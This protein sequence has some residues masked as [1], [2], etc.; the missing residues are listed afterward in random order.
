MV[1]KSVKG[2]ILKGNSKGLSFL[3]KRG[4]TVMI[5]ANVKGIVLGGLAGYLILSKG[6]NVMANCVRNICVAHQWKN[7]YKYGKDGNMVPPGYASHTR[8]INDNEEK[9]TESPEELEAKRKQAQENTSNKG[10]GAAVAEAIVKAISDIFGG[11]KK[12]EG[13]SE[14][15]T[16]PCERS[17]RGLESQEE[18]SEEAKKGTDE[19]AEVCPENCDNCSV[20][21]CPWKHL[22]NGGKILEWNESGRPIAGRYPWDKEGKEELNWYVSSEDPITRLQKDLYEIENNELKDPLYRDSLENGVELVDEDEDESEEVLDFS[23][24]PD[25]EFVKKEKEQ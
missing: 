19:A 22:K 18:A 17:E 9:V 25:G 1:G 15:Q 6:L 11:D 10:A 12:A 2:L 4:E 20:K 3:L 23:S 7:Y 13:A 14:G 16:E 8:Q 24:N 5:K 21:N